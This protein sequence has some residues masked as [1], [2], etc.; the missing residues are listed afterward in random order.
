M[1]NFAALFHPSLDNNTRVILPIQTLYTDA[2]PAAHLGSL[3]WPLCPC[4]RLFLL[5]IMR[6][7]RG[8]AGRDY[9]PSRRPRAHGNAIR[10]RKRRMRRKSIEE[11]KLCP[12]FLSFFFIKALS[13]LLLVPWCK[14]S[15]LAFY[16]SE[17]PH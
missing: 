1:G 9:K 13:R 5:V 17:G 2:N 4:L 6:C 16:T 10:G 7:T 15:S 14:I 8:A 11:R 3:S 12:H